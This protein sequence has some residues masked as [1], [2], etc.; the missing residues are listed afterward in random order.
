MVI[1]I[2]KPSDGLLDRLA[3]SMASAAPTY[4]GQR[5]SSE[6]RAEEWSQRLRST[7]T[8]EAA[9]DALRH[10]RAHLG[11][12]VRV[13]PL[14]PP[15]EGQTIAL[16]IRF[17]PAHILAPCRVRTTIDTDEEFGFTYATL[18]GHP[19]EGEESFVLRRG[20]DSITF[21]ITAVSRPADLLTRLGGPLARAIQH[22]VTQGYL[23]L[24]GL[25]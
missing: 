13:R 5:P 20:A 17:G 11:A 9:A 18:P 1:R 16:A 12:G 21:D 22:K 24:E 19:E 3:S 8:W 6:Y 14:T 2:G 7:T 25:G 15:H 23:R 10:W 4:P